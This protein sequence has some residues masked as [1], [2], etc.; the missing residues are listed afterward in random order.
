MKVGK[1][2]LT[3]FILSVLSSLILA[4]LSYT[5]LLYS[6]GECEVKIVDKVFIPHHSESIV[7]HNESTEYP[8]TSF[9]HAV[10]DT[11]QIKL[12]FNDAYELVEIPKN[13]YDKIKKGDMIKISYYKNR[14]SGHVYSYKLLF[15]L[16]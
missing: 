5:E 4:T 2:L 13:E 3:L 12:Q 16:E 1:I 14:I 6:S 8:N 7:Y 11:W 10:D 9:Y 15:N